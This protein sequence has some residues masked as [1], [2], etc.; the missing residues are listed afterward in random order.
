MVEANMTLDQEIKALDNNIESAKDA[1]EF[2]SAVARLRSNRDFKTV[3][4]DG[5]FKA[6]AIRLVHLKADPNMQTPEK[7][8]SILIQM[9]AI[10]ACMQYLST[11]IHMA[12]QAAR[13]KEESEE[14]RSELAGGA[15][16]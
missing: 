10:G 1:I 12:T 8:Q 5:L 16:Q 14:L 4:L 7:Q 11:A 6:E 9:D 15:L 13:T 3:I 2:G